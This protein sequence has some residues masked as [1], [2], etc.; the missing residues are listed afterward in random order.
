MRALFLNGPPG[1]GKDTIGE[2]LRAHH[3]RVETI[4]FAQPIIDHMT[5]TFGVSCA[6]G[7][8]K[9]LPCAEL[10]GMSRRQYAIAYSEEWIKP[11]FGRDWFGRKALEVMHNIKPVMMWV[12]TDSGF[13]EEARPVVQ[14]LGFENCLQVRIYRPGYSFLGDSRN[15]W[16]LP[17]LRS[18]NFHNDVDLGQLRTKA[19]TELLA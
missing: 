6:D 19:V 14:S 11:R 5:D 16:Q 18:I 9:S 10:A 13:Q 12:V 1:C 2:I 8:D 7:S 15:Y 4:K 17:K 3:P